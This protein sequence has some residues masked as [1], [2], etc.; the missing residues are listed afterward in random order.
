MKIT[1]RKGM[2]LF[3]GVLAAALLTSQTVMAEAIPPELTE[4]V[5]AALMLTE[6]DLEANSDSVRLLLQTCVDDLDETDPV[7]VTLKSIL[8]LIDSGNADAASVA[9]LLKTLLD[10]QGEPPQAVEEEPAAEEPAEEKT[11]RES[12]TGLP[13]FP[14]SDYIRRIIRE[15]VLVNVPGDWGNNDEAGRALTSYSP[16]NDSGAISPSAGTLSLSYFPAD[17][18]DEETAFETYEENIARMSVTTDV[19]SKDAHAAGLNAKT[20]EYIMNVGANQFICETICFAYDDMIYSIELM[21]GPMSEYDFFPVYQKVVDSAQIGSPEEVEEVER[22]EEERSREEPEEEPVEVPAEEPEPEP[23]KEPEEEP[24]EQQE[25]DTLPVEPGPETDGIE[26][27]QYLLNGHRYQFPTVVGSMGTDLP[28][29]FSATLPYNMFPEKAV[30]K[31][32][33]AEIINTEYFV[34]PSPFF[35]EMAAVTNMSGHEVP[36]TDGILTVLIDTGGDAVNMELPCGLRV[37]S[38][39]ADILK[40]FP[41]FA[42][43]SMDGVAGFVGNEFIYACNVRADGCTGYVIIRND[44]PYYSSVSIICEDQVIQEITFECLGSVRAAGIFL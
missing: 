17:G 1:R 18:E 9:V 10:E 14:V 27:F 12:R 28:L 43:L 25:P 6:T 2:R 26:S 42:E 21:Q 23:E 8:F 22:E 37:G 44:A 19:S 16:I 7:C 3:A 13:V 11:E 32:K 41:A 33:Y 31:G 4:S 34:L 5:K 40:G 15:C 30:Q 39:E 38:P 35:K 20:V 36:M 29:D 24:E